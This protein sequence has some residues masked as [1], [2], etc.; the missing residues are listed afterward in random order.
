MSK[1]ND[2]RKRGIS[3]LTAAFT[4]VSLSGC[5]QVPE[6]YPEEFIYVEQDSNHFD[7]FHKIVIRDGE[8]LT[9]YSGKN[10]FLA[11]DKETFDVKEYVYEY[12]SISAKIYDL[13]T[14]YMIVDASVFSHPSGND[15]S[16]W[17][18]LEENNYLVFLAEISDYLEDEEVKEWYTLDEIKELEPKI[19]ES[20]KIINEYDSKVK[21]K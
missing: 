8:P 14:G 3:L 18:I 21:V 11:Y 6:D 15:A 12:G 1:F 16:N 20:L 9:V 5:V 4:V 7:D 17:E 19:I 10:I 2:L 13:S